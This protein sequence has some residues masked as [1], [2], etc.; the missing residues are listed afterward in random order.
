MLEVVA[1][2]VGGVGVKAAHAGDLVAEALLGQDLGDA[3]LGHP[4]LMAV[5]QAVRGQ[6]RLDREPAGEGYVV[7][8]DLDAPAAWRSVVRG[9]TCGWPGGD[10]DAGPDGGVGDDELRGRK[11]RRA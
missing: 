3:V 7:A 5:P 10:G 11:T 1:H 6:A 4:G 9:R 2:L 8:D